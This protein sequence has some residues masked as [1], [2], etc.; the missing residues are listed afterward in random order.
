M[1]GT[2]IFLK[3]GVPDCN[4]QNPSE[5]SVYIMACE[6]IVVQKSPFTEKLGYWRKT[7]K[8]WHKVQENGTKKIRL[9]KLVA[10]EKKILAQTL[11]LLPKFKT[12]ASFCGCTARFVSDLG[13]NLKDRFCHDAAQM[14][15]QFGVVKPGENCINVK[16][17]C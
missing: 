16:N 1:A 13:G 17:Y 6:V 7:A 15:V 11:S 14:I 5:I 3:G 4:F 12:L 10:K 9:A 2:A 8:I